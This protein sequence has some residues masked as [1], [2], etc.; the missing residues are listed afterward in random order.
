MSQC[1]DKPDLKL[2]S[3]RLRCEDDAD[4]FGSECPSLPLKDTAVGSFA[5]LN[6]RSSC[7]CNPNIFGVV[8]FFLQKRNPSV[9]S[10]LEV[11]SLLLV[12]PTTSTCAPRYFRPFH[13]VLSL[14]M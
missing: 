9:V 14:P 12:Q 1:L 7:E 3:Y 2:E 11:R 5:A 10:Q 8:Y 4:G 13:F 6:R